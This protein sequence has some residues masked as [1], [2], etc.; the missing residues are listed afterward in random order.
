MCANR[1]STGRRARRQHE[2]QKPHGAL[3]GR[4]LKVGPERFGIVSID[5]AKARSKWM[6]TDFYGRVLLPPTLVQHSRG[7]F[8]GAIRALQLAIEKHGLADTVVAV[9]RTGRYHEPAQRAFRHAGFEVR[10]VHPFATHQFRLPADPGNKT[11]ETDLS[12]IHRATVNGFGFLEQPLDDLYANLRLLVRHRRDLVHKD[13]ALRCQIREHLDAAMPGFVLCF[14]DLFDSQIA[15]EIVRRVGS[16]TAIQQADVSGLARL[17]R[18]AKL[19]F[20]ERSLARLVA[21]ARTAPAADPQS[22]MHR[23]ITLELVT[24]HAAKTRDIRALESDIAARLVTT[25]YIL[26]LGLPGVN[27]VSAA[28]FAGEMGPIE[29]YAAPGAITGRAG[30]FPGRHQSDA[31]DLVRGRIQRRRNHRLRYAILLIAD[32]LI[33]C[34]QHFRGLAAHWKSLGKDPRDIHVKV[35]G[36]FCR[37]AFH[38]VAGRQLVQHPCSRQRDYLLEKLLAFYQDHHTSLA[39]MGVDVS[40]AGEQIPAAH[41]VEEAQPLLHAWEKIQARKTRAPQP[42]CELLP[43]LLAKLGVLDVKSKPEP[44]PHSGEPD[45]H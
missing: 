4:V 1:V 10:I 31:V 45:P 5:C 30:L 13:T 28:E 7:G 16:S 38:I 6:L 26:L 18:D 40:H 14:D 17:L 22:E 9:E 34:N 20:Q 8:D 15:W 24:D 35:A 27:V 36:R 21:W 44:I 2:V 43:F 11:D 39:Q 42:L 3:H 37:I 29:H 23:R 33:R 19:R 25:P 32:N 41:R 12:A